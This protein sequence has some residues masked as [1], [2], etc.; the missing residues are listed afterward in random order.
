MANR[1][2]VPMEE[3]ERQH[4]AMVWE[5]W[6]VSKWIQ[7][8]LYHEDGYKCQLHVNTDGIRYQMVDIPNHTPTLLHICI[9]RV[10][11]RD[12]DLITYQLRYVLSVMVIGHPISTIYQY[13][14]FENASQAISYIQTA[15][16]TEPMWWPHLVVEEG[17][18]HPSV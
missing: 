6:V 4:S 11:T 17:Q 10:N 5:L 1:V 16:A 12:A 9:Q 2:F 15:W 8:Q 14:S 18:P 7:T 13:I 3:I